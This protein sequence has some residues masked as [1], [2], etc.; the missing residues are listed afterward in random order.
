MRGL[1]DDRRG[2]VREVFRQGQR[3]VEQ[4]GPPGGGCPG[5]EGCLR[6]D[7]RVGAGTVG[8]EHGLALRTGRAP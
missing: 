3:P 5:V 2:T 4:V 8:V 7:G 1:A 6:P